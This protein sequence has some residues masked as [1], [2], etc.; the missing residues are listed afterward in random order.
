[1]EKLSTLISARLEISDCKPVTKLWITC[2]QVAV[3]T[4]TTPKRWLR[5]GLWVLE[6]ALIDFSEATNKD[7]N[8]FQPIKNKAAYMTWLIK[9][10]SA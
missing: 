5:S 4:G 10:W 9:K 2:E 6:H 3:I 1:M 7:V 8:G